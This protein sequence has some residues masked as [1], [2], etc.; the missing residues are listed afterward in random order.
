MCSLYFYKKRDWKLNI[1]EI[2]ERMI[3]T[4]CP[5]LFAAECCHNLD[6]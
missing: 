6:D 4:L 2:A 5:K 3:A 1:A